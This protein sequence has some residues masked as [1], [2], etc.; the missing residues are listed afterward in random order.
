MKTRFLTFFAGACLAGI[1]SGQ[2][3]RPPVSAPSPA[4]S[5]E[6]GM[7]CVL[8][9]RLVTEVGSPVDGLIEQVLVDRGDLVTAGQVVARLR[10]GVEEAEV[11]VKQAK[12]ELG[13]RKVERIVEM[14]QKQ[15]ISEQEKDEIETEYKVSVAELKRE[16]ENIR[17]RT[18]LSPVTGIVVERFLSAGEL[19][20]ADKSKVVRLAQIDPLNVEVV[21]PMSLFGKVSPNSTA[22]V[23]LD[24]VVKG[25][26][27][28][29]V[30]IVDRVVDAASSTFGIRLELRNP[31]YKIP[32]GIRCKVRFRGV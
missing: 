14:F 13:K 19:I 10:S 32:A 26:Y 12:V 31:G 20:R 24:P 23:T 22:E 30:L 2:S 9:P 18:I 17:L 16:T 3:V 4:A 15:L 7:S 27:P 28:V 29:R 25:V 1:A 21:A 11:A 6:S 8:E 5:P